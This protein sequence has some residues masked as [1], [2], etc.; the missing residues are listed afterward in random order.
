VVDRSIRTVLSR[1]ARSRACLS[2][3]L[4]CACAPAAPGVI[5]PVASR[6]ESLYA[7]G[8]PLEVRGVNY[9]HPTGA[10]MELCGMLQF[11]ADG[12]CVWEMAPIEHDFDRLQALGVN[13]VRVFLN[14]YVFGGARESQP[15]YD[16]EPA[17]RHFEAFV[18]AA[19]KR[20]IYVMPVLMAKYPQDTFG[21][22]YYERTLALHV[23]PVVSRFAGRPGILAWD[24]FNEPDIGSP[25]NARCW[26]WDNADEPACFP[27]AEERMRFVRVIHDEVKRLDPN[28]LVTT[29]MAFGKSYFEPKEAFMRMADLVDFYSMHYYDDEPSNSGRYALHW[30]YGKGFPADLQRAI[31]ELHALGLQKPI[32][33]S[34][35]GFPTGPNDTRTLEQF[36][37]DS[38]TARQAIRDERGVGMLLWPFQTSPDELVGQT[39]AR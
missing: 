11:G 21:A 28:R 22:Q 2:L 20:G 13:T 17:L 1:L 29:S 27:M 15:G 14:Y 32:L 38:R 36:Y 34:E 23:R 24:L 31:Q 10:N 9:T 16:L 39:F 18:E 7:G 8:Q 6:G 35:L 25:V 37:R 19:N 12:N 4:L 26:D 3:V 33:I 5:V 30:Y